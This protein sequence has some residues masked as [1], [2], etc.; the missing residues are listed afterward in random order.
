MNETP[1]TDQ[2]DLFAGPPVPCRFCGKIPGIMRLFGDEY[3]NKAVVYCGDGC[4][5]VSF[6]EPKH[7]RMPAV[8]IIDKATERWNILHLRPSEYSEKLT[9]EKVLS[10]ELL[11][12]AYEPA[13]RALAN[14]VLRMAYQL[15]KYNDGDNQVRNCQTRLYLR[16]TAW[17]GE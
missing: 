4:G 10:A 12:R 15:W 16:L 13:D 3:R 9:I 5:E 6:T 8:Q 7:T 1:N 17:S 2:V 11:D 14:E